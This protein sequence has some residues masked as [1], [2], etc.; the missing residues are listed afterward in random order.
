MMNPYEEFRWE[1]HVTG[2]DDVLPANSFQDAVHK[3]AEINA[4]CI[5]VIESGKITDLHP[6]VFATIVRLA[7]PT[8]NRE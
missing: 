7:A 2:P 6:V 1:V 8:P 5:D 3:A 4:V